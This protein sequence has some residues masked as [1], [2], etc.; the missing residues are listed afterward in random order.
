MF[1]R[2]ICLPSIVLSLAVFLS[3]VGYGADPNLVGWWRL[4]DGSG[5]KAIDSSGHDRHGVLI[6]NPVWTAGIRGGAMEFAGGN[7]VAVPGYEGILGTHERTC[8]MWIKVSK[9]TASILSWGP[10]GAGTKWSLR[11]HN[12]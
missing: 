5:T 7:H 12:G 6:N 2:S 1:R 4:N 10:S 11:T 3:N 9:T 8:M